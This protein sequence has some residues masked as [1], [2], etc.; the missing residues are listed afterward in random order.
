MVIETH[1]AIA[2]ITQGDAASAKLL[3]VILLVSVFIEEAGHAGERLYRVAMKIHNFAQVHRHQFNPVCLA[4]VIVLDM[5]T[6][7]VTAI[8]ILVGVR[9]QRNH[10]LIQR[11]DVHMLAVGHVGGTSSDVT[12]NLRLT[13]NLPRNPI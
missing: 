8:T 11:V 3:Q 12:M 1:N 2:I 5:G 13:A 9:Y 10:L 7:N 6:L 4:V